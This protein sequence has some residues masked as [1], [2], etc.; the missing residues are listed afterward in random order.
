[1]RF[2]MKRLNMA[3]ILIFLAAVLPS[4]MFAQ[5]PPMEITP[6]IG[7]N[8]SGATNFE[9]GRVDIADSMMVGIFFSIVEL[10]GKISVDLSYTQAASTLDFTAYEPGYTDN[11]F[12]VASHYILLGV[13]KDFLDNR[14]R[15]FIGADIGAAWFES[16]SSTVSDAWFF[17][18]DLKGG[19]KIYLSERLGLR[20][21]GRFLLPLD[22]SNG[23]FFFGIGSGGSS[24]GLTLG[25][26]AIIYQGDFSIGLIIR[27]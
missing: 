15:L 12:D 14:I 9:E 25:G 23:G 7:Y 16:K 6:V 27:I 26:T 19:M 18:F 1:M 17:A 8:L 2:E 22:F 11:S 20:L 21:Q 24:G 10:P 13:N 4:E 5:R 3:L